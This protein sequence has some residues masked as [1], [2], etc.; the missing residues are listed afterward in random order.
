[1]RIYTT[2]SL[3][4]ITSILFCS[5]VEADTILDVEGTVN[6][7][8]AI[9][10]DHPFAV[11]WS[12]SVAYSGVSISVLLSDGTGTGFAYLTSA[13]GPGTT[14]TS[15]IADVNFSYSAPSYPG[16]AWV[17]LFSDLTLAPGTYYLT[18]AGP[19]SAGASWD[20]A[21]PPTVTLGSGVS[22][23]N[24]W[25]AGTAGPGG[26]PPDYSYTLYDNSSGNLQIQVIATPE[27]SSL[28]LIGIGLAI[29]ALM[30]R[31]LRH[32]SPWAIVKNY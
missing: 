21:F 5:E 32:N 10:N 28:G 11:S 20:N 30:A 7:S 26:Y 29:F 23:L 3:V 17:P 25:S 19:F 24:T 27:P 12:S 15:Q 9:G 1:M 4:F 18:L 6:G 22:N 13:L 2:S 14:T 16:S 31:C 8:Q